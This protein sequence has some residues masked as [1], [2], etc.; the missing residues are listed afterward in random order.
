[1]LRLS[2]VLMLVLL[3]VTGVKGAPIE[4]LTQFVREEVVRINDAVASIPSEDALQQDKWDFRRFLL[5]LRAKVGFNVAEMAK[6]DLIPELEHVFQKRKVSVPMYGNSLFMA[7]MFFSSILL[8][9]FEM[10][11][12]CNQ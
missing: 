6:I 12:V 3:P 8:V 7:R 9:P 2:I 5:R 11:S 1:M 10:R 4:K